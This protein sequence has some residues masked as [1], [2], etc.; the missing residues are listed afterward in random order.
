MTTTTRMSTP[1]DAEAAAS[2]ARLERMDRVALLYAEITA[3]TRGFLAALA[4]SDRHRDWAGEGFGSCSEWLAWRLGIT[5]NTA[6]E[7]VRVA[8]A[9]ERLPLTSEA[10]AHGQ[11]SF[12][13][14][15][16][17]TR[18][19]TPD[20]ERELLTYARSISAGGLERFVR[21]WRE[22]DG[23]DE[24][25]RERRMHARRT[26]SVFPGEDGMYVVRGRL[27]PEVAAVLMRAIEAASDALYAEEGRGGGAGAGGTGVAGGDP[28][29]ADPEEADRRAAARRRAD[30]LGLLAERALADGLNGSRTERYQVVVHLAEGG[31]HLDDGAAV[32]AVTGQRLACDAGR[33]DVTHATDGSVLDVGRRTRTVPAS[34]RRALEVRDGGC[35]FPACRSRFTDAHHIVHWTDGGE[36]RL[37]NLLLLCKRHH[38]RVHEGGVTVCMD[39]DRQVVFFTPDGKAIP[40]APPM[41]LERTPERHQDPTTPLRRR[42]RSSGVRPG[43]DTIR[44]PYLRDHLVPWRIEAAAWEAVDQP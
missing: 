9:L 43:P 22:I 21:S 12:S 8:R 7:K 38:R 39:R 41:G 35:R 16:A 2:D 18:V 27:M 29:A 28:D 44:P 6:N 3:A 40:G 11:L 14:V 24:A 5:R 20:S 19:A 33:V 42:N 13:K 1:I 37:D 31:A 4:E 23:E 17:L 36:T 15:R 32:T 25:A 10:M 34:L 30:A 26:L